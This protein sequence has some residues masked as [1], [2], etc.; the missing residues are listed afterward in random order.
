MS[1]HT[2]NERSEAAVD[3]PRLVRPCP[4]CGSENI[5]PYFWRAKLMMTCIDC[6]AAGPW[7]CGWQEAVDAANDKPKEE[8]L[9]LWNLRANK[10]IEHP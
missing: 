1:A 6:N 4:F 3:V 9:R 10:E 7:A 2:D 5:E 8:A